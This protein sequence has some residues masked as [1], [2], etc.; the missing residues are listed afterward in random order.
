MEELIAWID[1]YRAAILL[2]QRCELAEWI[3]QAARPALL[4]YIRGRCPGEHVEDVLQETLVGLARNLH[5]FRGTTE[6]QFWGWCYGVAR[7]KL[8][9]RF[10]TQERDRLVLMD[11]ETLRET[12]EASGET[13]PFV[14]GEWGDLEETM[15]LL[16][17]LKP[18]CHGYLVDL[19]L[20]GVERAELALAEGVSED[21]F[22]MRLNRCLDL[23]QDLL[24]KRKRR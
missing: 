1:E 5:L 16:R 15:A 12:V 8:A 10:R 9:N 23:M 21:A 19:Y 3:L 13:K 4:A 22:R 17:L 24:T 2:D 7:K 20:H 14:P 11:P 6:R 18:P